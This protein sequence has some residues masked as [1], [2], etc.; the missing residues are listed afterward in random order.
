MRGFQGQSN[1]MITD[2]TQATHVIDDQN[3]GGIVGE[4]TPIAVNF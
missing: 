3:D 1:S 4:D 2:I